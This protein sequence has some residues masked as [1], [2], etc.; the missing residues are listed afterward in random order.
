MILVDTRGN[1]PVP[2]GPP[3]KL[4]EVAAFI[5]QDVALPEQQ[6]LCKHPR[7][8]NCL[9]FAE[10]EKPVLYVCHAKMGHLN[11]IK[12][13][14]LRAERDAGNYLSEP[15]EHSGLPLSRYPSERGL[16]VQVGGF[17][18][19]RAEAPAGGHAASEQVLHQPRLDLLILRNQRLRELYRRV[20]RRQRRTDTL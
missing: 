7:D 17:G 20:Q 10:V 1:L 15:T 12:L 2:H 16:M 4:V 6:L 11:A 14:F 3:T 18:A 9:D 13:V 19:G 8:P 5:H